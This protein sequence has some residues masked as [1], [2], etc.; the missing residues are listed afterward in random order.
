MAGFAKAHGFEV[1]LAVL[2][3]SGLQKRF[4]RKMLVGQ[5]GAFLAD[6]L[7]RVVSLGR[8]SVSESDCVFLFKK[9]V[10]DFPIRTDD[11][12]TLNR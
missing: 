11:P 1:E 3:Q 4:F 6:R 2:I 12:A 8:L 5:P 7:V 10:V 9:K